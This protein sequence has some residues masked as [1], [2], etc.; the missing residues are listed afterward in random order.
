M[1][2]ITLAIASLVCSDIPVPSEDLEIVCTSRILE[3][4]LGFNS[5]PMAYS[6][7]DLTRSALRKLGSALRQQ[8]SLP[9]L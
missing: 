2:I 1:Y 5:R 8:V 7:Q 4:W 3:V 6:C 9:H